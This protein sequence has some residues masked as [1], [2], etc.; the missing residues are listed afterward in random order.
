MSGIKQA[1]RKQGAE[2]QIAVADG[3]AR[4]VVLADGKARIVVVADGEGKELGKVTSTTSIAFNFSEAAR[5][6][7]I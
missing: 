7:C 4:R 5:V 2:R 6:A 3:K 1:R